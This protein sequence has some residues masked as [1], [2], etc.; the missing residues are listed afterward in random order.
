[1]MR[2]G[3]GGETRA[4]GVQIGVFGEFTIEHKVRKMSFPPPSPTDLVKLVPN[5][6]EYYYNI[7]GRARI[8]MICGPRGAVMRSIIIIIRARGP[9]T[10]CARQDVP[11]V[12]RKNTKNGRMENKNKTKKKKINNTRNRNNNDLSYASVHTS[13]YCCY[14]VCL[15]TP[16]NI[17][18]ALI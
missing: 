14:I 9:Q 8:Y 6:A 1:M 5:T 3:G 18:R 7:K 13:L 11:N 4:A 2:G 12:C 15:A 10:S 16:G 17:E